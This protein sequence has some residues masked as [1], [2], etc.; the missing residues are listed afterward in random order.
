MISTII[1]NANEAGFYLERMLEEETVMKDDEN[2]YKSSFWRKEKTANCP[3][4]LV[5]I[6]K[7][8]K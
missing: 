1:N 5:L 7:K 8:L 2:G 3:S 4:T 6:L